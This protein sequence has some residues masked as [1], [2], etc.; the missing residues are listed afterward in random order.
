ML[1]INYPNGTHLFAA[2]HAGGQF[3][4]FARRECKFT[5]ISQNGFNRDIVI[6]PRL[7]TRWYNMPSIIWHHG[8]LALA[9]FSKTESTGI[10]VESGEHFTVDVRTRPA[11]TFE[12]GIGDHHQLQ[13]W[14]RKH[15]YPLIAINTGH[16][17]AAYDDRVVLMTG[18]LV[19]GHAEMV[20]GPTAAREV[21][22]NRGLKTG[23]IVVHIRNG[24]SRVLKLKGK[25]NP[26][27]VVLAPDGLT[28]LAC[29]NS[30]G[31]FVI[32]LDV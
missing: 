27:H 21:L 4:V 19:L 12:G 13:V 3:W 24:G 31:A 7:A 28:C 6:P 30:L 20:M 2:G 9:W 11:L 14:R 1:R 32:D 17:R 10:S 5:A 25:H 15:L 8:Q 16:T 18:S 29:G 23:H 22:A 26:I